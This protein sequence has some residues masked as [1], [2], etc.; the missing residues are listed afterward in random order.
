LKIRT[1][2]FAKRQLTQF[3][4]RKNVEWMELQPNKSVEKYAQRICE[5]FSNR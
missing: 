2:Q 3:R 5:H 4:A 1:R